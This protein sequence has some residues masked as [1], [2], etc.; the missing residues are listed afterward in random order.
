MYIYPKMRAFDVVNSISELIIGYRL[1]Q[2]F[3]QPQLSC[4][5]KNVSIRMDWFD[6]TTLPPCLILCSFRPLER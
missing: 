6:P 3:R 1:N 5:N 2:R 4:K